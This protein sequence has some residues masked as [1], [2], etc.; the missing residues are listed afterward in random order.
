MQKNPA[1]AYEI[2]KN[3]VIPTSKIYEVLVKL[4]E[5]GVI[6]EFNVQNKRKYIPMPPDEMI[7]SYRSKIDNTLNRLKAG[8]KNVNQE[9]DLAYIWNITDYDYLINKAGRMI[10]E[11][12][13]TLLISIWPEEYELLKASLNIATKLGVK[14]AVVHFRKTGLPIGQMFPH[15]IEDTVYAEKGGGVW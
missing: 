14:I 1:T 15:P 13:K 9:N 2:A 3:A 8:L 6:S 5:K 10:G 4:A 7:D 11:A 12:E